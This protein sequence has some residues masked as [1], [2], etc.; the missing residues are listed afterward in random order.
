[1][2]AMTKSA[3]SSSTNF[4]II[5]VCHPASWEKHKKFL[6]ADLFTFVYFFSEIFSY[7][8]KAAPFFNNLFENAKQGSKFLIIDF[9]DSGISNWYDGLCKSAGLKII[10]N[11]EDTF[12]LSP[13]ED[14]KSLGKYFQKFNYQK[15]TAKLSVR[16]LEK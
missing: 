4:R 7:K 13:D 10:H 6:Q 1:V 12:Q 2:D 3:I 9:V 15:L 16:V 8:A 5:N 14:K 11:D